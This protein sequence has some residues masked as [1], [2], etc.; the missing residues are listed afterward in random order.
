MGTN[1]VS[2][3]I[4]RQCKQLMQGFKKIWKR[5]KKLNYII[6]YLKE[7]KDT[8]FHTNILLKAVHYA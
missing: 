6:T 3:A 4:S 1:L 7:S 8:I 5:R 2:Q